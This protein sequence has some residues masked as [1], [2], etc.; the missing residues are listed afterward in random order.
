LNAGESF[1]VSTIA[2]FGIKGFNDTL[3]PEAVFEGPSD[4]AVDSQGN[5]Y[6]ADYLRIRKVSA[7]GIVST[8]AGSGKHGFVDGAAAEARF[9]SIGNLA[10]D[11]DGNI[12]VA[13]ENNNCIRKITATGVVSTLAGRVQGFADGAG[14]AA[15]FYLPNDVAADKEGNVYVADTFNNRIRKISPPDIVSTFA[16][17]GNPGFAD[18]PG[19]TAEFDKP[20]SVA[21]D[22]NGNVYVADLN[23]R[24]IRV[25]TPSGAVSTLAGS[26]AYGF[27]D[28][29]GSEARFYDPTGLA[30]DDDG[31][32]YLCD[33]Y[34]HRVRRITKDGVVS[35]VAG[36]RGNGFADG[37]GSQAMFKSARGVAADSNGNLYVADSGNYRIRKITKVR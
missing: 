4:V 32:V 19:V 10:L 5:V 26:D 36:A 20:Q 29:R 18:G 28:G 31:N 34:N 3:A 21:V 15:Q 17:S 14:A 33:Q 22:K 24:R 27:A 8:L 12:Y 23:N 7:R 11:A 1:T 16:G 2:G 37:P 9:E 25:I 30:V 13:D 6:V 35:T